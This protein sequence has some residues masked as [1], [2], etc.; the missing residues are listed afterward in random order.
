M[1]LNI[2]MI[3]KDPLLGEWKMR[4]MDRINQGFLLVR[5]HIIGLTKYVK[6]VEKFDTYTSHQE[7]FPRRRD[8]DR[9]SQYIPT[10]SESAT[11][12]TEQE[13][14]CYLPQMQGRYV[15]DEHRVRGSGRA[16]K[17]SQMSL[18]DS[19]RFEEIWQEDEF[20]HQRAQ[21]ESY[22]QSPRRGSVDS[23]SRNPFQKRYSEDHD[24]RKYSY[25]S[26]RPTDVTRYENRE[27]AR[28]PKWKPK[29]SF[30]PFQEKNE[31]WSFGP[32][33]HRYTE[34]EYPEIS[35]AEREYPEISSATRVSYAYRHKHHKLS[36]SEQD[37]PNERFQKYLKEEDRKYS[38]LKVPGNRESDCFS[39][40]KE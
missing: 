21:E 35:S 24:F 10:Y 11:P 14:N 16:G 18:T 20:R 29:H 26:K 22:P 19:I 28:T 37:F 13:R 40:T 39:T 23:D 5:I 33:S 36:D 38:S 31:D 12:Y 8:D 6:S 9:I 4:N 7:Y 30:V 1:T 15:T 32:Q 27:P 2:E 17:P 25:T 34:R 3:Q